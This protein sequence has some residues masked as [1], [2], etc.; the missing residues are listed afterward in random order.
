MIVVD[1]SVWIAEFRN[2][3]TP[4]TTFLRSIQN[5]NEILVLDLVLFELLQGA[6]DD[7]HANRI[8]GNLRQFKVA[9]AAGHDLVIHA[10]SNYRYLRS[11]GITVRKSIDV[12]IA[13][14]CIENDY[15]LLHQDRDF[16]PFA[17]HLGL[18]IAG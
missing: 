2:Q 4:S 12:I 6:R 8:E 1:S 5:E 3:T 7:G 9:S 13:T 17:E 10:A 18:R 14:F 15:T 16:Q 11:R